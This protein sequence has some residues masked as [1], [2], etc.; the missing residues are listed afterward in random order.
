MKNIKIIYEY[1]G[2]KFF[3]FQRQPGKKTVQGNIEEVVKKNFNEKINLIS[4]GRTDR[5]VHALRQVSNF[6]IGKK[7]PNKAIE[8]V[9]IRK[10]Y[11]EIRILK[12]EEEADDFHARFSAKS[13]AY[14]YIMKEEKKISPFE[15]S[16]KAAVPEK[17]DI[18]RFQ[19]I[20]NPF[21]GRHDF[22]N[23]SKKDNKI[24]AFSSI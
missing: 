21:I 18:V 16:Y 2:S 6:Y 19:K 20:L 9:L 8:E 7:I 13:R 3:G 23:F 17:M 10:L 4:S 5:G 24:G 15:S 22:V 11:K 14:L 1:D 12:L